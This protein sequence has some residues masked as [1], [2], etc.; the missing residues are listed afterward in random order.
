MLLGSGRGQHL[1]AEIHGCAGERIY[2]SIY[3]IYIYVYISL[4]LSFSPICMYL[5]NMCIYTYT[6]TC[7]YIYIC[8]HIYIYIHAPFLCSDMFGCCPCGF[9]AFV[10]GTAPTAQPVARPPVLAFARFQEPKGSM[11]LFSLE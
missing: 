1:G 5:Y 7:V 2:I 8:V 10:L 9:Q 4:S 3:Y 6:Q 11:W